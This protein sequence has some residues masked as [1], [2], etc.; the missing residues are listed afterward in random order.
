M[1]TNKGYLTSF[2]MR[3]RKHWR[4]MIRELEDKNTWNGWLSEA[5]LGRYLWERDQRWH[6]ND[7]NYVPIR[8]RYET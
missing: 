1:R 3:A 2:D 7:G 6:E 8:S 4:R 5:E